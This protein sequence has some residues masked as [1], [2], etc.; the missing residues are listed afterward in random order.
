MIF[1]EQYLY[2]FCTSF[3]Y[4]T[5][6]LPS[7]RRVGAVR[8]LDSVGV[9]SS[10]ITLLPQILNRLPDLATVTDEVD[11]RRDDLSVCVVA[12]NT[13]VRAGEQ[14]VTVGVL[15]RVPSTENIA[16]LLGDVL[17]D[18]GADVPSAERVEAPVGF[19]GRDLGVVVVEVVVGRAGQVAWNTVAEEDGKDAVLLCV[20]V[21]LV[22]GDEDESVLHEAGVVEHW[23]EEVPHPGS[24]SGDGGV[25][26]VGGHVR[27]DD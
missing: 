7:S 8:N 3:I 24:G 10:D 15:G 13:R 14:D 17:E 26:T 16:G 11:V 4:T 18:V 27:G 6:H 23:L 12:E 1:T 2:K 25:V 22:K 5:T 19:D 21:A 9:V 20:G